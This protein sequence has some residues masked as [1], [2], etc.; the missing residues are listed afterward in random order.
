MTDVRVRFAPSPTGYLHIGGARTALFN[1]LWARKHG[2]VF[3]LRIEDTDRERST[4]ESVRVVLESMKWLGLDWDEGPGVG[5]AHGPYTQMERLDVYRAYADRMIASGHAYR[6]YATKD[7]IQAAREKWQA[8]TGQKEG[9]RF[10]SPWRDETRVIDRP[11]VVRLRA[12]MEGSIGWDDLVKGRVE[13]PC[14]EQQDVILLRSDGVP[15]YNFGAAVDDIT[16]GIT[17]VGRGDDHLINTPIQI[18]I[19]EALGA[20]LPDMAH[21]P[22]ILGPD[23]SKLSKRH[24]AVGVLEWRDKGYLPDAVLNYLARLGWSHGDQEIFTRAE[25]IEKFDWAHCGKTGS[26]YD[27][28]KFEYVE[29]E[30]LRML[31]NEELARRAVPFVEARGLR[32]TAADPRLV[33]AIEHV[34]LRATTLADIADGVDYFLRDV[35]VMDEKAKKKFLTPAFAENLRAYA[36]R[37]RATEPFTVE[38]LDRA[39]HAWME[40]KGL[41]FKEYAQSARVALT[42]RTASPG[43]FEVMAILGKDTTVARLEAG[44]AAASEG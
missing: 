2:G 39:T 30:H 7:D 36:E 15:L 44:V 4:E 22:M 40:E 34:K 1:W 20:R 16:M 33:G 21:L 41:G 9:F 29:A 31:S 23:G 25:L 11:H 35:P 42:G 38:A 27:A 37:V 12:R 24:A 19:Y 14:S 18:Q 26:K 13:Y 32:A 10:Q 43:L 28:K 17:V 6:C 8:E 3:V 5:G